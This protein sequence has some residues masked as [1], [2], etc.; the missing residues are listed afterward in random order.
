MFESLTS[1]YNY[2]KEN[3]DRFWNLRTSIEQRLAKIATLRE[4]AKRVNDQETLGRLI[5]A[6]S[7]AKQTQREYADLVGKMNPFRSL[8]LSSNHLGILPIWLAA[9]AATIATSLY[10]LFNKFQNEGK[11]LALIERGLISPS[12]AKT[13]LSGGG[14]SDTLGNVSSVLMWGAAAYALF[15]VAPLL[16]KRG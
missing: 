3:W 4:Q 9:G 2:I 7:Q 1:A 8:I 12:E 16:T 14:I 6:E 10:L 15:L 13:L 5:L 11:A